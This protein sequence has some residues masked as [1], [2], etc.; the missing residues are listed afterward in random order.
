MKLS[1]P[2]ANRSRQALLSAGI[3]VFLVNP[4][5]SLTEVAAFAGVGRAT[6]YRH[7]ETREQLIQELA[8]E[9]LALTDKAMQ[10]LKI[11]KLEGREAIEAML[12][13]VMPLANRFHF[14]LSLW[15]IAEDDP[16]VTDIYN[17]QLD[18]MA[19]LVE[20]GKKAGDINTAL[21]TTWIV[22]MID[23]LIYAGWYLVRDNK[24]DAKEAA[25]SAVQTLFSGIR[26]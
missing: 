24:C 20:Q 17:R 25:E 21:T 26:A 1:D 5:A 2:R 16:E 9:S 10:P 15:S 12:H 4:H 3:E 18:E 14:L 19:E 6:L 7:F 22:T 13:A 8:R 11:Q 23:C